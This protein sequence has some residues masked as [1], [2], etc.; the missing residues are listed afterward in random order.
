ME[1]SVVV[2]G[3]YG[4]TGR[5][6]AGPLAA[7]TSLPLVVAGRDGDRARAL[8]ERLCRLRR[9]GSGGSVV[10][11]E[12]D[13]ADPVALHALVADSR[14]IVDA[15][16][17]KIPVRSV[18]G[19][20]LQA[21]ADLVELR[22]P[23]PAPEDLGRMQ[24]A[25]VA[26][27]RSIVL[28]AGFHP[29]TPAV[30][31]RWAAARM[32]RIESAWV[33]GLLRQR[34]GIP[35]TPAVDDLIESFRGYRAHVFGPDGWR[36]VAWWDPTTMPR[37]AFDFGFGP[38]R[39]APMDLDELRD[40]PTE[41]PSLRRLGFSVA[42][43][44]PVT[45]WVVGSVVAAALL[46]VRAGSVRPLSRLLC[47]STRTFGRPPFGVV[48]QLHARGWRAGEPVHLALAMQH[49]DGY[50]LTAIPAVS[51]IEQLLDG[52][53]RR[54]GIHLMGRLADPERL[55]ADVQAMGVRVR[56]RGTLEP[57]GVR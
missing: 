49:A 57:T 52:T 39:T 4:Q 46:L 56:L 9:T 51:M 47:W 35:L 3:G 45:D 41:I 6:I 43:F 27:D 21:G 23:S 22:F 55:L 30:L 26:A 31:V 37:V 53:G 15:T 11:T 29:G 20:A 13:V 8:A 25:A 18:V 14:L 48:V 50:A 7:R 17:S 10:G 2:L 36:A 42:G 32:D 38:Q 44:D 1:G 28:Q 19:A 16:S 34:G 54:P 24:A 12:V 33:A 40:L 5:R